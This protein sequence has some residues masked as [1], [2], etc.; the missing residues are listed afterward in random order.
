MI[1]EKLKSIHG[2]KGGGIH[3]SQI[4][5]D[6]EPNEIQKDIIHILSI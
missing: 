4:L 1:V 5:F 6:K 3:Q 2:G